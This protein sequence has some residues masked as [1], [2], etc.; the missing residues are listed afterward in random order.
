[1][2][3]HPAWPYSKRI[4]VVRQYATGGERPGIARA[5]LPDRTAG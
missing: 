5:A 4:H 1:M 3:K 2:E